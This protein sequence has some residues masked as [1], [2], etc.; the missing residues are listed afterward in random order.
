MKLLADVIVDLQYG[1]CGKGK[2]AHA[3]AKNGGYAYVMRYNGGSNAGHTV[4]HNGKKYV[5]HIIPV[6]VFHGIPSIVGN[7][8]VVNPESFLQELESLK[9]VW[10]PSGRIKDLVKI[11]KNAHVVQNKHVEEEKEENKLGTTRTGNGPA[12]RDKHA[13][14]GIR[15]E[16][17]VELLPFLI[18]VYDELHLNPKQLHLRGDRILL[19]GAQGFGLDIDWGDYPFVSSSN[20]TVAAAV[21]AG[22]PAQNIKKVIGVAKPYVTYVGNKDFGN[23]LR[24]DPKLQELQKAGKEFGATTGRVR[25]CDWLVLG[26]LT[27]AININGVTEVIF[28]KTDIFKEVGKYTLYPDNSGRDY[29]YKTFAEFANAVE[30]TIKSE[31][32]TVKKIIWSE[33]PEEI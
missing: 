22:I 10:L 16:D 3:L 2:V 28:N 26:D 9:D 19:E 7:G 4:Y 20:C 1:D 5:T 18:N 11:A 21:N 33:S 25:K 27:K 6:G 12:Y 15:A 8:C 30:N 13:R 14:T 23:H 32:N 17:V 29:T 31:C 24:N